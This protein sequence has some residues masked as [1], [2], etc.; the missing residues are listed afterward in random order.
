MR[1]G[2]NRI[3]SSNNN[4]VVGGPHSSSHGNTL[5]VTGQDSRLVLPKLFIG[6]VSSNNTVTVSDKAVVE[7]TQGQHHHHR[8]AQ[9]FK[10]MKEVKKMKISLFSLFSFV[11]IMGIV[12]PLRLCAFA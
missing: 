4:A 11:E 2:S 5:T 6:P 8:K 12:H 7:L 10:L 3:R 9:R 1:L